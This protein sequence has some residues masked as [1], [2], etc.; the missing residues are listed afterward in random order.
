MYYV[1]LVKSAQHQ[2]PVYVGYT[3]DLKRR[4]WEHNRKQSTYTSRYTPWELV[5]YIAF[6]S[7]KKAKEFEQYLKKP[8][9]KAFLS[10]R[11]V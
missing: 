9:G 11:F 6:A 3:C 8:S 4:M 7:Q 2:V 5:T 10:K 1:Y